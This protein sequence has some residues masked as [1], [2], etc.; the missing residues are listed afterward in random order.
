MVDPTVIASAIASAVAP[1]VAWKVRSVE[2]NVRETMKR[3][4]ANELRSAVNRELINPDADH[5]P[6]PDPADERLA[7]VTDGT[8]EREA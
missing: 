6:D 1:Y 4:E 7:V 8:T 2:K 5:P 3:M